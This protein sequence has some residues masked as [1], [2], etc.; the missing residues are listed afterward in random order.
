MDYWVDRICST[1]VKDSP[2][3]YNEKVRKEADL[4][5]VNTPPGSSGDTVGETVPVTPFFIFT[6]TPVNVGF[7]DKHDSH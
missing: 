5:L 1:K 3:T 6:P 7:S 4:A 2:T